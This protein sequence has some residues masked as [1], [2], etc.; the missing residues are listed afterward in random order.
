[1]RKRGLAALLWL[2]ASGAAQQVTLHPDAAVPGGLV[3]ARFIPSGVA[4]KATLAFKERLFPFYTYPDMMITR[5]GV[6]ALTKPGRYPIK[7]Y[8]K[9][10]AG[11]GGMI[12]T[13]LQVGAR[14]FPAQRIRLSKARSRLYD[15]PSVQREYQEIGAALGRQSTK[16]YGQPPFSMP[17]KGRTTTGYGVRR[18][19]NGIARGYH[20]ALDLGCG[21][22]QQVTAPAPAVVALARTGYRL[23]GNTVVLDHGQGLTTLYL[24]LGEVLVKEGDLVEKGTLIGEVGATGN[25][26]GPH[27]HWGV[28]IHGV[29]V[30]AGLLVAS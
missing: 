23:H 10:T 15:D 18:Y 14:S 3:Q 21:H 27:L 19:V 9:D 29:P 20:R 11:A 17:C 6:D 25:T 2:A 4:A 1:M 26:T 13:S 24:H 12:T 30:D 28:Y 8:W 22:G 16:V 5:F 7:I